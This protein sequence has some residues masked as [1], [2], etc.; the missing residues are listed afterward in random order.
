[1]DYYPFSIHARTNWTI[2]ALRGWRIFNQV[3]LVYEENEKKQS[4]VHFIP[5]ISDLPP[6]ILNR[7]TVTV[8]WGYR[9]PS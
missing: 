6:R 9:C 5:K 4:L 2:T 8:D 7:L 1:M 3:T